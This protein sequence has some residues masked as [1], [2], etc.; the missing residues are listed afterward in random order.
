VPGEQATMLGGTR[1][2]ILPSPSPLADNHWDI[3]PWK[4][5]AKAVKRA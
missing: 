4:D 3:G 5:L 1:V 2:W